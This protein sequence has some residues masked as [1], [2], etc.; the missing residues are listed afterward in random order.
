MHARL[1]TIT[2]ADVDAAIK[3]LE[4][5]AAPV[6]GQ[7]KGIRQLAASGDPAKGIVS[8]VSVFDSLADLEASRSAID[9]VRQ[10]GLEQFGGTATVKEFEQVA[11]GTNSPPEAG[12]IVR[13]QSTTIDPSRVDETVEWFTST[14]MPA[15]LAS[16][17]VKAVRNLIDR[18]TGE[19]RVSVVF[20]DQASLDAGEKSRED[21][22]AAARDR[23]VEFGE[24]LILTVRYA[25]M[26]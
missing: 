10:G 3:Y 12:A 17:G 20:S 23:G 15:M 26:F 5:T 2:G 22:M 25:K 16:P 1:T 14:V 24:A 21:R 18:S 4:E 19:G 9:K 7:Q 11:M 6:L 8:I 13:I